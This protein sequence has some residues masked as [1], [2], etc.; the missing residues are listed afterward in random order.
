[1][2]LWRSGRSCLLCST[3]LERCAS[4]DWSGLGGAPIPARKW[5]S[6]LEEGHVQGFHSTR[7][8]DSG[9]RKSVNAALVVNTVHGITHLGWLVPL[10]SMQ[11]SSPL[12]RGRGCSLE[13]LQLSRLCMRG[14]PFE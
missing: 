10:E 6:S 11:Y 12:L 9:R 7:V 1:M 3:S 4:G 5:W 2:N 14:K 13:D 8:T